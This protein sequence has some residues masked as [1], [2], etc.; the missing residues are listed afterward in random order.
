MIAK[1]NLNFRE[2]HKIIDMEQAEI[3]NIFK[4]RNETFGLILP[5]NKKKQLWDILIMMLLLYTAIFVPIKVAFFEETSDSLF[6]FE[7]I[8]DLLFIIDI[9][10]TFFS[11]VEDKRGNVI[12]ERS[13]IAVKY[14]KGWFLIDLFTSIPF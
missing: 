1:S 9:I 7:L 6:A 5:S 3:L 14:I 4:L 2:S 12:T 11:V 8:V 10:V 13:K